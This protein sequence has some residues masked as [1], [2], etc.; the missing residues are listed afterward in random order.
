MASQ[1]PDLSVCEDFVSDELQQLVQ[2]LL[3]SAEGVSYEALP[4]IARCL[5][6]SAH[7]IHRRLLRLH[8]PPDKAAA[9]APESDEGGAPA[10]AA[11][12]A[13]A[14]AAAAH[15]AQRWLTA[16]ASMMNGRAALWL[17]AAQHS[18][19]G[20][21]I[22]AVP[23]LLASL[24]S[25][26]TSDGGADAALAFLNDPPDDASRGGAAG[27]AEL[28][29]TCLALCA[30]LNT[31][32]GLPPGTPQRAAT[33][34]ERLIDALPAA[35][36]RQEELARLA[37]AVQSLQ[38]LLPADTPAVAIAGFSHIVP[39]RVALAAKALHSTAQHSIA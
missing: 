34:C 3:S 11:A 24:A 19:V 5:A 38:L 14:A 29:E 23:Q 31:A 7:L 28:L 15:P 27:A 25:R 8:N 32:C 13:A 2:D 36:L 9:D 22:P 6:A 35:A 16:L 12:G 30:H 1:Q 18:A 4:Q 17:K 39:P 10:T 20:T 33:Q 21:H 37:A 26:F